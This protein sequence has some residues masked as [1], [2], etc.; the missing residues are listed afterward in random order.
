MHAF[1]RSLARTVRNA[2]D[3]M[4]L[5]QE[6]V[7]E[8]IETNTRTISSIENGKSNTR[9]NI[10]YPLVRLLHIDP[11]DIFYPETASD[12]S[13]KHQLCT[14]IASCTEEEAAALL[15]TAEAVLSVLRNQNA[16]KVEEK[17]ACLP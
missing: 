5:T 17:R 10:L 6:Q 4:D 11:N 15:T 2:R 7:G 13:V 12:S 14:L 8:L 1:S 3:K 16:G 9:M